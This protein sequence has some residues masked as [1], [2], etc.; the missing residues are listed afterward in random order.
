MGIVLFLNLTYNE[1]WFPFI[2]KM[3]RLTNNCLVIHG[4]GVATL[5]CI[6]GKVQRVYQRTSKQFFILFFFVN[7]Y[8][9]L[10]LLHLNY[11]VDDLLQVCVRCVGRI[12]WMWLLASVII[13]RGR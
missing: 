6:N 9:C 8:L 2:G 10:N 13:S 7:F 5:R 1:L 3:N 4:S 11:T 12:S